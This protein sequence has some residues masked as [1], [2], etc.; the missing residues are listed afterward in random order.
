MREIAQG[1]LGSDSIIIT[2]DDLQ[3][4]IID[5]KVP[6]NY[7]GVLKKGLRAEVFSSTLKQKI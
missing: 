6:E 7:V 3:K 2:L 4:V 1:V 5:I